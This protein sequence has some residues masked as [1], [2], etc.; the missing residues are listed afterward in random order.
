MLAGLSLFGLVLDEIDVPH[1][2]LEGVATLSAGA[3]VGLVVGA[4]TLRASEPPRF[5]R[6]GAIAWDAVRYVLAFEMVRYGLAKVVGMQFYPQY[7]TLDRRVVDLHPMSLVW[8]FFG[9]SYGYQLAGGVVELVGDCFNVLRRRR[10]VT[11][12]SLARHDRG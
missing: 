2:N 8:A 3:L 10:G 1:D 12:R 7:W 9:R 11:N 6:I 5:S 4:V